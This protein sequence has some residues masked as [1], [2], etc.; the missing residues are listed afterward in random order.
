MPS[1]IELLPDGSSFLWD[2][3]AATFT[4]FAPDGTVVEAR[5]FT[6]NEVAD[7]PPDAPADNGPDLPTVAAQVTTLTDAVNQ[8]ILAT[9]GT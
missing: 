3:P 5:P 1:Y 7:Y 8:L 4:H 2:G 9:L 6:A